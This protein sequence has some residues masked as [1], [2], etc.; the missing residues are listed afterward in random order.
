MI[1]LKELPHKEQHSY[2]HRLLRECLKACGIEYN[3][4]TPI[5][6][7]ELGKPSLA[8]F[9]DVHYNVTHAD[10]ITA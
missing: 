3:E 4:N 7:G 5:V 1:S 2:A 8:E 10:G 9:P 6:Y